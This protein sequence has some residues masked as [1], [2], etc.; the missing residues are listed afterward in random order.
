MTV[1]TLITFYE[2]Q[3]LNTDF[4][5]SKN[6]T[7]CNIGHFL[8]LF[9]CLILLKLLI[10]IV[11]DNSNTT[12]YIVAGIILIHFIVGFVWLAIKLSKKEDD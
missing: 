6:F 12:L 3:V 5:A 10:S 8:F 9:I 1:V 7:K 4:V 2:L 11:M